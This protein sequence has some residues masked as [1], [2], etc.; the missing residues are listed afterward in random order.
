MENEK[1]ETV[2]MNA[3]PLSEVQTRLLVK[4]QRQLED[5]NLVIQSKVAAILESVIASSGVEFSGN[6]KLSD[7]KTVLTREG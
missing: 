1:L 7:D 2:P 5:Q 6:W 3:I 4:L